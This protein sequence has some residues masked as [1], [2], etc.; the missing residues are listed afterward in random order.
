M[1][2]YYYTLARFHISNYIHVRNR[3][4]LDKSWKDVLE[5]RRRL[6]VLQTIQK[7]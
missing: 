7:G 4:N 5:C 2:R 1:I 6:R 3:Q